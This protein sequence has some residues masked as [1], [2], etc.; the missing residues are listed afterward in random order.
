MKP[1]AE[2]V[3]APG[4]RTLFTRWLIVNWRWDHHGVEATYAALLS[5]V[6]GIKLRTKRHLTVQYAAQWC[7]KRRCMVQ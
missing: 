4:Y 6:Y 5:V 1:Q 3:G 7:T 2:I